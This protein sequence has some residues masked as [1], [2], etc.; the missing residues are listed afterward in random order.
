MC[1]NQG[2]VFIW[3]S[4]KELDDIEKCDECNIINSDEEALDIFLREFTQRDDTKV[5]NLYPMRATVKFYKMSKSYVIGKGDLCI[6]LDFETEGRSINFHI[7]KESFLNFT[8]KNYTKEILQLWGI[9]KKDLDSL[10][11]LKKL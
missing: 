3:S 11:T 10:R 5:K 6:T 7:T 4:K 8:L 1:Y 2:Y 9:N